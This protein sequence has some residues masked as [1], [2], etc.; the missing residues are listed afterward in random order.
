MIRL[1][2]WK[3]QENL[4]KCQGIFLLDK[5]IAFLSISNLLENIIEENATFIIAT[6]E[7][8]I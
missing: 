6:K 8:K 4:V 5:P 1:Y 3:I 2:T 7:V